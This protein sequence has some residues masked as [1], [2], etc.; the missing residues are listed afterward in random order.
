LIKTE[1]YLAASAMFQHLICKKRLHGLKPVPDDGRKWSFV[2]FHLLQSRSLQCPT[3][4]DLFCA[5]PERFP[6]RINNPTLMRNSD[7]IEL[8]NP[9][10]FFLVVHPLINSP[11][12][13]DER[14]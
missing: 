10:Y 8:T 3:L 2:F 4:S 7:G 5:N 6:A 9:L 11:R 12:V 14:E 1:K 13:D